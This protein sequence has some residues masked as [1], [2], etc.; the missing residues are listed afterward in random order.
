MSVNFYDVNFNQP[1]D[2][3]IPA[4]SGYIID[5]D[6]YQNRVA[7]EGK[8]EESHIISKA[9]STSNI[10]G[11]VSMD[12]Y[13]YYAMD[14]EDNTISFMTCRLQPNGA[15]VIRQKN[16]ENAVYIEI[17]EETG[18][19]TSHPYASIG[20]T[21][22]NNYNNV[23]LVG[24]FNSDDELDWVTFG[25]MY[26]DEETKETKLYI[27]TDGF[28]SAIKDE[29]KPYVYLKYQYEYQVV[30]QKALRGTDGFQISRFPT[31]WYN[32]K[33]YGT[34]EGQS[35]RYNEVVCR[36]DTNPDVFDAS[37]CWKVIL[38][39]NDYWKDINNYGLS[40]AMGAYLE[41]V[42]MALGSD[43]LR[44]LPDGKFYNGVDL[45]Q[46]NRV[47][48]SWQ[49]NTVLYEI[50]FTGGKIQI[51]GGQYAW[52]FFIRLV[53]SEDNV[54]DQYQINMANNGERPGSTN[55]NYNN[56]CAC[57][58]T[59]YNNHYYLVGLQQFKNPMYDDN[60]TQIQYNYGAGNFYR[61]A[62]FYQILYKFSNE[63]NNIL[64]SATDEERIV[65]ANPDEL[66]GDETSNQTSDPDNKNEYGNE[67]PHPKYNDGD[68]GDGTSDGIRGSGQ[69]Q[70]TGGNAEGKLDQQ[71]GL[72]G[73]PNIPTP[74]STGFM[75]LYAPTES[76]IQ[77]LCIEL[78]DDSILTTLKK[79]FGNN[80]LDFIVG[81]QV[82]P[83]AFTKDT[84]KY[85]IKYGSYSS[86]VSMYPITDEFTTL[87]YGELDLKEIYGSW[88]DYNPHTKMS[89]YLPYIGIKEIDPDK[90]NGTKLNLKYHI[91]AVTGSI[92]AVL[93]SIRKD[94]EMNGKEIV[95]GQWPGQASYTIPLTNTQ[96][97]ASV[98][99][100]LG[101]VGATAGIGLA[102]ATGG[103]SALVTA[104]AVGSVGNALLSG[105]KS[106]KTDIS[107]QGSVGGGLSFFTGTDA[108]IQIE[109][110][111]EGRPDDYNHIIGMPSNITTTLA[112]QPLNNYIEFV[113][114]DVSGIDAPTDEK[115]AIVNLLKGG[116][117][118]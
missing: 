118:T 96:H 87:D 113:N 88:E 68:W 13:L 53:D 48:D 51:Y 71:P 98:N 3:S 11:A 25:Y 33:I 52:T 63:G 86:D 49:S 38:S 89:I 95:V 79:Y 22:L 57:Y 62:C 41:N 73:K 35:Q 31:D 21:Y 109:F 56:L 14:E 12:R 117:Y 46:T 30:I 93:T 18:V 116:V 45:N 23:S 112:E 10:L 80:P 76:E 81:L 43:I 72:P 34:G 66:T 16:E 104:G 92:L 106:Q 99:A 82:V 9:Q 44:K 2:N 17:W 110:P 69:G 20:L 67:I 26:Q 37:A 15:K 90:I 50:E 47:V 83:G 42:G 40:I 27:N 61:N 75:K 102:V 84:T 77:D 91:D 97:D 1:G 108:Y 32:K 111:K 29:L 94:D 115:N 7:L 65:P 4:I 6:A 64:Y 59:E 85:K 103:A 114:V 36:L 19:A 70:Q 5:D 24:H 54:I 74:V 8:I 100:V 58:L 39:Q 55:I 101:I 60:G 78:T 28:S 105:A 107:M